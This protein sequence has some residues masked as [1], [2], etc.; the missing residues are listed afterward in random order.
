MTTIIVQNP[1]KARPKNWLTH[2]IAWRITPAW[3]LIGLITLISAG[4]HLY[5]IRAIGN[6]NTYYTAAVKSMLQ[7]W[8]NFFFVAAEPGGSVTIDKPPLG[9]WIE[10][11]FAAVLGVS[12]FS[13]V[14]P[15]ILAGVSSVPLLYYLVKKY[16]G[17]GAGLVAAFALALTPVSLAVDRNNTIDGMLIFTLLLAAWAFINAT[18]TGRLKY[19][20]LGAFLVGLGFNIK[21]LQ[22]FLPLPAFYALYFFGAKTSWRRKTLYLVL[23]SVLLAV[24]SLSWAVTVDLI[25]ASQRPYVGGTSSNSEMELIFGYNGMNRLW[26]MM[27]GR[28]GRPGSQ[29]AP[30]SNQAGSGFQPGSY[31]DQTG[32][33]FQS[34]SSSD[35][36]TSGFQPG[37][38]SNQAGGEIQQEPPSN[39]MGGYF[40]PESLSNQTPG[41]NPAG[42]GFGVQGGGMGR[43]NGG[44][45]GGG[46]FN[47]GTPGVFRFFQAPLAKEMSWVLPFALISLLLMAGYGFI[48]LGGLRRFRLPL[49]SHAHKALILWGGW[50][51]T[52]LVF[53]SVAG[54]FH[55]YYLATIAPASAAVVGIGFYTLEKLVKPSRL[56]AT[57]I[58]LAAAGVTIIFQLNLVA[59]FGLRGIW[60]YIALAFFGLAALAA[61]F[62]LLRK[63]KSGAIFRMAILAALVAVMVIP[64]IWSVRTVSTNNA[65]SLPE[66]FSGD[67][68]DNR[69]SFG[70]L[71]G[72]GG[73]RGGG[74]GG[75]FGNSDNSSMLSYLEANT[76]NTKYLVAVASSQTGSELVLETGRPVLFMG[77]FSG[78]DPVVDASGLAK[79]VAGGKLRYILYGGNGGFGGGGSSSSD[80]SSW[81][82]SNCHVVKD[83]SQTSGSGLSG[84]MG[85]STL[86]QC[87]N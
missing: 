81:I 4:L 41:A 11:A 3:I 5:N 63:P 21:M 60:I 1:A 85:G 54:F 24:V 7:S 77:G 22:A 6:S 13:V 51:V 33:G 56:L 2:P 79:L 34:R 80:I 17:I 70:G 71:G 66:A 25:P 48:E 46:S 37:S 30:P 57:T 73:G 12:G 78:S 82:Q 47:T 55:N 16:F 84:G 74:D 9:L 20:L 52:C 31:T 32:G 64:A 15:N 10:T 61:L 49:V 58:L 36:T 26:G 62:H 83:I 75:N 45:G 27:G 35:Q 72:N 67:G 19:L 40:Q 68:S 69:Q 42:P 87:G 76:K 29:A 50:L 18:E 8:H 14:L 53:F 28:M 39:Q 44:G 86:Y 38:T 65:A 59:Q 23:A 43:P